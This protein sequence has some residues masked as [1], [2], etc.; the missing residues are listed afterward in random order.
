MAAENMI[1]KTWIQQCVHDEHYRY[2]LHGDRERL[3]DLLS[4]DDVEQAL[5]SGRVLELYGD[6]GRGES[7]LVAGF[8]DTGKP[9]HVVCGRMG[10][11]MVI[12]TIYIPVSPKFITPFQRNE[13]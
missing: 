4:L 5:L 11:W 1:N 8:S 7:C 12:I 3:N 2:S 9:V 13:S 10:D 6:T